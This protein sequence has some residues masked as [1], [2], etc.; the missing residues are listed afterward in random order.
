MTSLQNVRVELLLGSS[1]WV[2]VT[3]R[4]KGGALDYRAGRGDEYSDVAPASCGLTLTNA[5][6]ALTPRSQ[7][8]PYWPDVRSGEVRCRIRAVLDTGTHQLIEG[9]A[10]LQP[11]WPGGDLSRGV[12]AVSVVDDL[13][14][15]VS[16]TLD[17]RWTEEAR[18]LARAAGTWVDLPELDGDA[19]TAGLANLGAVGGPVTALGVAGVDATGGS[20]SV[21]WGAPEGGLTLARSAQLG[22]ADGAGPAVTLSVQGAPGAVA[23]WLQV[24]DDDLTRH[25]CVCVLQATGGGAVGSVWLTPSG[26]GLDLQVA[27]GL[28][29]VT[30]T[31]AVGVQDGVWRLLQVVPDG[32]GGSLVT[33]TSAAGAVTVTAPWDVA[34]VRAVRWGAVSGGGSA[35]KCTIAGPVVTGGPTGPA[36]VIGLPGQT[37]RVSRTWAAL[38]SYVPG[39]ATWAV[40]GIEDRVIGEPSW[41]GKTAH[42]VAQQLAR[43]VNGVAWC[44]PW[45]G[46]VTLVMADVARPA[47]AAATLDVEDDVD[48]TVDPTVTDDAAANPTRVTITYAGGKIVLVDTAA[49]AVRQRVPVAIDTCAADAT[50]AAFAGQYVLTASDALRVSQIAV[51]L[52]SAAADLWSLFLGMFPS[53][54]LDLDGWSPAMVGSSLVGVHV[55]GWRLAVADDSVW[56]YTLDCAPAGLFPSARWGG[57]DEYGRWAW[58]A[59]TGTGGTAIATTSTGTLAVTFT[60]VGLTLDPGQYP[61]YLDWDG[62]AV[63]VDA[64][65]AAATSPQTVTIAARGQLDTA[66][67]IHVVGEAVDIW[68]SLVWGF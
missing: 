61:I 12:V 56:Q 59:A 13:A 48:A 37:A 66:A 24:G 17:D 9:A 10:K 63:R 11:S 47:T 15:L 28:I 7:T 41:A 4:H 8:S 33:V 45:D 6:G 30:H 46:A 14:V 58:E 54:L 22:G 32:S 2:D 57:G 38:Q 39:V 21:S 1:G 60:G 52:H 20:G 64:P 49:E 29:T 42:D 40:E 62:E 31:L 16:T 53:Q 44:R 23:W 26:G 68:H 55:Q 50:A 3:D 19:T 25:Q 51:D 65:P 34:T 5:D 43:T 35:A 27:T 36:A 18:A 67:Q